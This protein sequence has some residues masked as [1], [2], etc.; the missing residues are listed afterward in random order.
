MVV[1]NQVIPSPENM[2]RRG[3]AT[4]LTVPKEFHTLN[5]AI[6]EAA[7]T[8]AK[9]GPNRRR[10]V[11]VISEGKEY[12]SKAKEK[13]VIHF[14]QTNNI[15]VYGTL[16]G[17]TSVPGL[18][19]L[20]RIHLPLTMRDDVLP[21][22]AASTGGQVDPEFRPKGIEE[23]FARI[24]ETVRTQYTV[25]YYSHVPVLDG[26]FRTTEIRVLRSGLTVI[27][28]PGY[29]PRPRPSMPAPRVVPASAPAVQ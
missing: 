25:G 12:G 21:R 27:A 19:F 1:N 6:L 24:A 29:Y 3:P 8:V 20:D 10:L 13:D 4:S 9:A 16:V 17:D 7:R 5:D 18:G 28:P 14:L 2:G 22:Y 11:Y 26:R 15:A 23:S